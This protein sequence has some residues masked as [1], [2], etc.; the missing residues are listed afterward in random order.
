M[1][2]EGCVIKFKDATGED[3][4]GEVTQIIEPGYAYIVDKN[5]YDKRVL[6]ADVIEIFQKEQRIW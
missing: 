1:V 2:K 5:S 3:A 6:D 4:L